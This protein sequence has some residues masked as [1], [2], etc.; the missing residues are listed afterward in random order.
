[1]FWRILLG[2]AAVTFV[3]AGF[4]LATKAGDE[5]SHVTWG[6]EGSA[7]YGSF[8]YTCWSD[9]EWSNRDDYVI[10][11]DGGDRSAA[12][13][14]GAMSGAIAASLSFGVAAAAIVFITWPLLPNLTWRR[15]DYGSGSVDRW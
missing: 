7:R 1:M 8:A 11:D 14:G 12:P 4:D 2:I 6:H 3:I 5:C 15:D 10:V 9:G 13:H